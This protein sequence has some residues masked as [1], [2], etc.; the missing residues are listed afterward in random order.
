MPLREETYVDV[1]GLPTVPSSSEDVSLPGSVRSIPGCSG[2]TEPRDTPTD[3]HTEISIT[4]DSTI[5]AKNSKRHGDPCKTIF[6]IRKDV[7][8]THSKNYFDPLTKEEPP[9]V[10]S[11]T[12]C[13]REWSRRL[14]KMQ[15]DLSMIT[16]SC[17]WLGKV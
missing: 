17:F 2:N 13:I 1:L 5:K 6:G 14:Y 3:T 7:C 12:S 10:L 16:G 15:I 4:D 11:A 8:T 9:M